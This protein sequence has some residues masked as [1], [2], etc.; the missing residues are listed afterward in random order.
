MTKYI[1][2]Y[3]LTAI[4]LA[5]IFLPAAITVAKIT[6]LIAGKLIGYIG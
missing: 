3:F 1:Y 5:S 4:N 2:N 6:T